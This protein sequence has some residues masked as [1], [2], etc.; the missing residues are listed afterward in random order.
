MIPFISLLENVK[1]ILRRANF[2]GCE[3]KSEGQRPDRNIFLWIA[4]SIADSAAVNP[5]GTKLLLANGLSAV[6][7]K[8]NPVFNNGPKSLPRNS[9]DCPVLCNWAFGYFILADEPFQKL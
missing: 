6:P 8:G 4:A 2:W 3:V 1:V 9:P 5:N 7:I